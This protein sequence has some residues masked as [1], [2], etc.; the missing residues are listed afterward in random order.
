MKISI[1]H[2]VTCS[3]ATQSDIEFIYDCLFNLFDEDNQ[4]ENFSQTQ[5]TLFEALFSSKAFAECI[6]AQINNKPVGI[7][8][9]SVTQLNFTHFPSPGVYVHDIYVFPEYRRM[10]VAR[11][12]GD[13]IKKIALER[14]FCRIDGI[15]LKNN[16]NA[17]AFYQNIQD[18][19]VLD[20]IYYTRLKLK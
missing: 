6:V 15:I 5:E 8:L 17:L 2:P 19:N 7:L 18:L 11:H 12:L 20:Y 9:F 13:Y 14:N 3:M 10:G 4:L 1:P 16:Q